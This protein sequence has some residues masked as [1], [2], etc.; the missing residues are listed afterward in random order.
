MQK[1]TYFSFMIFPE[2][3]EPGNLTESTKQKIYFKN[4]GLKPTQ[5]LTMINFDDTETI[6]GLKTFSE[7]LSDVE[8]IYFLSELEN[9]LGYSFYVK[10]VALSIYEVFRV[11]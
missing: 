5:A 11:I 10:N 4:R 6:S 3:F 1:C 2:R 7:K 9:F 8:K